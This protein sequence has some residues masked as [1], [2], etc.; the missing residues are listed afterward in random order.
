[1]AGA[2]DAGAAEGAAAAEHAPMTMVAA[3][4]TPRRMRLFMLV[5]P[6]PHR[7]ACS[8]MARSRR[9]G[10]LR[11]DYLADVPTVPTR[12]QG[13]STWP[14]EAVLGGSLGRLDQG[15]EAVLGP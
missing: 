2:A 4:A 15:N 8:P 12:K 10:P 14:P 7:R 11:A 5:K 13:P 3:N 1:M 9:P 6:P